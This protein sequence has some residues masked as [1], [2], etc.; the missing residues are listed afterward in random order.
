M[1]RKGMSGIRHGRRENLAESWRPLWRK[2]GEQRGAEDSWD[3]GRGLELSGS[4]EVYSKGV[5][6]APVSCEPEWPKGRQSS[7]D[8]LGKMA[9]SP[10]PGEARRS[11]VRRVREEQNRDDAL[12][13]LVRGHA[14][15]EHREERVWRYWGWGRRQCKE[16]WVFDRLTG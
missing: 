15:G 6:V 12:L 9:L 2:R 11:R 7:G 10:G 5:A 1:Q 8:R 14:N 16:V 4:R 3:Q 13:W